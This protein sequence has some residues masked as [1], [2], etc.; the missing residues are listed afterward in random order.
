[1]KALAIIPARYASTRFP[2][3]PLAMIG[4]MSMV[5]RVY[6]Q[7]KK[8]KNIADVIVATDDNRIYDHVI[9][10]FGKA[11]L[12]A[13]SHASGTD[14]CGEVL[15]KVHENFDLII[16]VQGDEPFIQPE[17][18]ELLLSAFNKQEIEVATLAFEIQ[19]PEDIWNPNIVKVVCDSNKNALYFSRSPIPYIRNKDAIAWQR[20][21][22]FK[23]HIGMY[24]FRSHALKKIVR[25]TPSPLEQAESLEQLRWMENGYSIHIL[26]T[27]TLNISIDT[28]DDLERAIGLL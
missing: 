10:H 2:G 21:F 7:V 1:M 12:T 13:N 5:M 26:T 4:G 25:L 19:N 27:P 28:P 20:S 18:I 6:N 9:T 3:K 22:P 23:K 17:Q 16:N 24:A 8:A 11:M 14:R 15:G